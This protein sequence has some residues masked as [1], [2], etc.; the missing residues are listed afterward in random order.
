MTKQTISRLLYA[1]GWL[2]TAAIIYGSLA[3]STPEAVTSINDKLQHFG[4]YFVTMAWF[5]TFVATTKQRHAHAAFLTALTVAL[6]YIQLLAP[7][8][9][10]E[11][12][13]IAYGAAGVVAATIVAAIVSRQ[14]KSAIHKNRQPD[15][16]QP[17]RHPPESATR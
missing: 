14:I 2:L 4:A 15:S 12:A 9:T 11:L 3:P 1:T 13:D 16:P 10:F 8:R 17:H 7:N 6:E 5:D